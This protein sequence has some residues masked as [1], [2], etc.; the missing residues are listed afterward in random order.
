MLLFVLSRTFHSNPTQKRTEM[1]NDSHLHDGQDSN[2]WLAFTSTQFLR[3]SAALYEIC[4]FFR[5]QFTKRLQL[6]PTDNA[7]YI[8]NVKKKMGGFVF[9]CAR[10]II[11]NAAVLV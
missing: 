2:S 9:G 11:L 10:A 5:T 7:I 1:Y 3:L 6:H 8:L 4:Y